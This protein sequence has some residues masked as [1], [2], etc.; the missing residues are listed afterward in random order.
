M[1]TVI[2]YL[3]ATGNSL[4][5]ARFLQASLEGAEL[6]SIP[7]ALAGG[8]L[9]VEADVVGFVF[10]LHYMGLPLQVEDFMERLSMAGNP[11]IFAVATCGVPYLG[12]PFAD[13]EEILRRKTRRLDAAWYLR[14]VSNYLPLR[15]TAADWRIR[16]R[17]W[18]AERKLK[19][20]AAAVKGR[21][22]HDTWQLLRKT[23]RR[24]HEEW[25]TR[26]PRIDEAFRCDAEIC[27]SCGL[28]EG[29]C[30]ARNIRRPDGHPVWQH[31]CTECLGCLH[32]CPVE[33]IEYGGK[34]KGRKRYRHKAVLPK[35]LLHRW[36]EG[37]A[38]G[39]GA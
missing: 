18:L 24:L 12:T 37:D 31:R 36:Q 9:A 8:R 30:P 34:T 23:C 13:A 33:A 16:I 39:S 3:S 5:T 32:I 1:K 19:T 4:Y 17:A 15:D 20:I 10:P 2:Y 29:V 7:E 26:Q 11:Y 6:R 35:D 27:T 21:R 28:C 38:T 22:P 25:K 14:L